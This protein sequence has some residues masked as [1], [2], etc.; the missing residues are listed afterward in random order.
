[1][2]EPRV[3]ATNAFPDFILPNKSGDHQG[4]IKR[5]APVNDMDL[6]NKKYVDDNFLLLTGGTIS[7]I[8]YLDGNVGGL[9]LDVLRSANISINL[10]VGQDLTVGRNITVGGTVDGVDIADR[11]HAESHNIASHSDT[12]A[13]GAELNSLTNNNIVDGLHRHS[14]LVAADGAPDPGFSLDNSGNAYCRGTLATPLISGALIFGATDTNTT[15]L[16]KSFTGQ[17]TMGLGTDNNRSLVITDPTW[18]YRNFDHG[19]AVNPTL[20]IHSVIDPNNDN[21]QWLS[22][23]HNQNNAIF[24]LG[25][26]AY[27]FPNG[28]VAIGTLNPLPF[29][30]VTIQNPAQRATLACQTFHNGTTV[31]SQFKMYKARGIEAS[32]DAVVNGDKVGSLNFAA[33]DGDSYGFSARVECIVD[34]AVSD[35]VT[36]LR[37]SF[38]TSPTG[39]AGRVERLII[40]ANGNIETAKSMFTTLG[41]YAIKL[42]NKTGVTTVKG[43]LVKADTI[44]DDAVVLTGTNDDECF[45]V[46]LD[47]GIAPNTEAWVVISG[48]ADVA[49]DDNVA[50]VRA[51]WVGT[52]AAGYA[53][54]QAAPPAL[55][56]A[57]HF[58]EI[59]HCIESVS[60]TGGGTHILARCVLHFN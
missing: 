59:G 20:W 11:D 57:A 48:I 45:G 37:L 15:S 58:E 55:G 8:L 43:Q 60:A 42:T 51:N 7:G 10:E 30:A 13:T 36:P 17:I 26:G 25:K 19:I 21:T 29:T 32:P 44:N 2:K 40:R 35:G 38:T 34:G 4:S 49:F 9:G 41:G 27:I 56:I 1:M 52:G 24:G 12:S 5:L 23:Y 54:T 53:R 3:R 31:D 16:I 46:F 33:Y 18:R 28:N 6:V 14:E 22:I 47:S 39:S 50:A